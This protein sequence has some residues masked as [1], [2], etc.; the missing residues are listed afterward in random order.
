M[1]DEVQV[2][3][4]WF[5]WGKHQE[6]VERVGD[7]VRLNQLDSDGRK[8]KPDPTRVEAWRVLKY[9]VPSQAFS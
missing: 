9:G 5:V 8:L 3:T 4:V 6:V 7:M 2:G 1:N